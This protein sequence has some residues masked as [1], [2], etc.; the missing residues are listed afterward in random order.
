M[1][2]ILF[3]TRKYPPSRGGMENLSKGLFSNY[4]E[5]KILLTYGG[6]QKWLPLIYIKFFLQASY[7]CVFTNVYQIHL[8]DGVMAPLG[9]LLHLFYRKKVS[10]T[11]CGKD[12][13]FEF[14]L[15]RTIMPF[16]FRRMDLVVAI[17]DATRN[18]CIDL[19]VN[20][21]KCFT[22]PCG[23]EYD[24]FNFDEYNKN[25][26]D[27]L[28]K[29]YEIKLNKESKV[30]VTVGRLVK[31]KGVLWFI[32]NVMPNL[33]SNYTYLVIGN[34]GTDIIGIK[35]LLGVKKVTLKQKIES[36]IKE[37]NLGK[38][39]F[40]LGGVNFD[41]LKTALK[42]SDVFVSPNISVKGD[43]EGFGIVNLEAGLAD[44]PV[45]ASN[46]EGITNAI[47]DG[48]TGSLVQEKNQE[49]F[50]SKINMW[51]SMDISE[52][53]LRNEVIT[54]FGWENIIKQYKD[55]FSNL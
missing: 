10:F 51:S 26:W 28:L 30:L 49:E 14:P 8:G 22:I 52:N 47:I 2:R 53:S 25:N 43:M 27:E 55:L 11:A 41:D 7:Y 54:N 39:V 9:Y 33:D 44:T 21:E 42:F 35:S 17:S 16:F 23:V 36:A 4:P 46:I 38:R 24:K 18:E 37:L 34:D 31:R 32:R 48:V 1:R 13:N 15:Y 6:S 5:P 19:G 50:I 45:V 3:I 40:L 12:I 20:P 29:R